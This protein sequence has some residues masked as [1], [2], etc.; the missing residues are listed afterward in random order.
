MDH[1]QS[2]TEQS[3]IEYRWAT[4]DDWKRAMLLAWKTFMEFEAQDYTQEGIRHFFEFITDDDIHKAFLAGSYPMLVAYD[5]DRIV[6]M[7]TLRGSNRLSLL[8]VDAEYHRQGIGRELLDRLGR[9]LREEKGEEYM[10]VKAAPYAVDFYRRLGFYTVEPERSIHGI[11]VTGM[12]K[13][14]T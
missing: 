5:R 10:T 4:P 6:G 12:E 13:F 8:F 3:P 11:L 1:E 7:G 14:L 2:L 9:F